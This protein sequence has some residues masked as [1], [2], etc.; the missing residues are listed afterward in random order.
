MIVK[1]K[2]K[3]SYSTINLKSHIAKRFRHFSKKIAP[4]HSETL[5]KIMDFF[6]WHGL[7]SFDEFAQNLLEEILNNRK[8]TEK[9]IKRTE[10]AIA[11]IRDIE[12]TQTRPNNAMLLSLFGEGTRQEKPIRREKKLIKKDP[13][14]N[15]EI[16]ITVPKIRYERLTDKLNRTV[17]DFQ[18]VL[19]SAKVVK[20]GFGKAYLKLELTENELEKYKKKLRDITGGE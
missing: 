2:Y 11:I 1:G 3:Y 13:E 14:K 15:K 12:I 10:A 7:T 4:S 5:E 16:E 6:E 18:H 17:R 9:S 8:R 19:D 20:K